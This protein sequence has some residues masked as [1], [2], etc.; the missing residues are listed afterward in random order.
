LETQQTSPALQWLISIVHRQNNPISEPKPSSLVCY[1]APRQQQ[2]PM[3]VQHFKQKKTQ[4]LKSVR[5]EMANEN[6][7]YQKT[8][9][10]ML[11]SVRLF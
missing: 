2:G 3:I 1:R 9:L 7:L 5:V 8:M 6:P 10:A 4:E 11:W